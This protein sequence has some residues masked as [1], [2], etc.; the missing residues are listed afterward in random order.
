MFRYLMQKPLFQPS[1]TMI[2]LKRLNGDVFSLNVFKI[3]HM[4][5]YPDTTITLV[6]GKKIVV[7]NDETEVIEKINHFYR[8]IGLHGDRRIVGDVE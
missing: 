3:E 2:Q 5:S 1:I 4:Q 8:Q 6:N 7:Q